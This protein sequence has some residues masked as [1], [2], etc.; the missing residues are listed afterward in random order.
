MKIYLDKV[1]KEAVLR[2]VPYWE[3]VGCEM[4]DSSNK[5]DI[6]LSSAS[7]KSS[8][9]SKLIL[10]LDS[11]KWDKNENYERQNQVIGHAHSMADGIIYQSNISKQMGEKYLTERKTDNYTVIYNGIDPVGWN[12]P[13]PHTGI[14]I[15]ACAKWRRWKRLKEITEVFLMFL[16]K[17]PSSL[18]HVLGRFI[19]GANTRKIP[20]KNIIYYDR[21]TYPEIKKIYE[22][23]DVFIHLCKNDSCPN[24]VVEAIAAGMPVITTNA[25]GGATEMCRLTP[26][27][28]V[29]DEGMPELEAAYIHSDKHNI[30][31]GGVRMNIIET[32]GQ[33]VRGKTRVKLPDVLMAKTVAAKYLSVMERALC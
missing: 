30:M 2:L 24:V 15:M 5:A 6:H 21:V 10:R 11:I 20:H 32:I 33:V 22:I 26:G 3:K 28:V 16:E 4:V 12:N 17:H 9:E 29:V 8:V 31:L 13:V 25:C 1:K 18:L 19:S 7:I 27:C 23:G 14:N